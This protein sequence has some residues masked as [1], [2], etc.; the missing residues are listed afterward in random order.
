[1]ILIRI[2]NGTNVILGH[3][4]GRGTTGIIISIISIISSINISIINNIR[5]GAMVG[6]AS[7]CGRAVA[8]LGWTRGQDGGFHGEQAARCVDDLKVTG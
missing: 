1:M 5:D 3:G 6:A 2:L 4:N 7:Q 8:A